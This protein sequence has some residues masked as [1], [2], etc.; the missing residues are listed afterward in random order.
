MN[1]RWDM[2]MKSRFS[3]SWT[4]LVLACLSL[5]IASRSA[6]AQAADSAGVAEYRVG[7][8]DVLDISVFAGGDGQEHLTSAVAPD[9][10]VACPLVGPLRAAGRTVADLS[11]DLRARLARDYYRDPRVTVVVREFGATVAV[12]GEVR[13]PG[14]YRLNQARTALGACVL[15]GGF[16][17]FASA[18]AVRLVRMRA[19]KLETLRLDLARV[20]QGRSEDVP[21]EAG[22]RLDI[23]RR[24]L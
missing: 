10:N 8:G 4:W 22:D 19:G 21:L 12:A 9:G 17:D 2:E 16:T 20:S 3:W 6:P 24:L 14:V 1:G 11:S 13:H 5:P 23:P 15:A 18:R 7:A